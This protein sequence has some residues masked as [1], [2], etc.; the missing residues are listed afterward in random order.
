MSYPVET[1]EDQRRGSG[2]R[3]I[4]EGE[5][6]QPTVCP[7]ATDSDAAFLPQAKITQLVCGFSRALSWLTSNDLAS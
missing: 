5:A 7:D 4:Q 6:S 2:S 3:S 1:G